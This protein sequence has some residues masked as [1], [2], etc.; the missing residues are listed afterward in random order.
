MEPCQGKREK[1]YDWGITQSD[2]FTNLSSDQL[3]APTLILA[4]TSPRRRQLLAL[5]GWSFSLQAAD[6]N[7]DPL[8]GEAPDAYVL[9][10]SEEKARTAAGRVPAGSPELAIVASDTTVVESGAILG[11]PDGDEQAVE[12]LA[13]LRGKVHQVY[14]GVAVLRR[15]DGKLRVDLCVTDVTMRPYTDAEIRA[16]VATGDPLDKAGA[17]AIQ[18]PGFHPVE[19]LCG[20]YPSVMGLPLCLVTRL[21]AELGIPPANEITRACLT[22]PSQPCEVYRR[23]V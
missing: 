2:R 12:M 6:I 15:S 3:F 5:G 9:R 10:L 13:R 11:K 1:W 17:Y 7:E 8:P 18:H 4:S 22:D 23:A 14:T 16:Y 19:R 21:L 20:C